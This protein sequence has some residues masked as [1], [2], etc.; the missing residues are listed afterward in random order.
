MEK[1]E[2]KVLNWPPGGEKPVS[3]HKKTWCEKRHGLTFWSLSQEGG[4][5]P[6]KFQDLL[7]TSGPKDSCTKLKKKLHQ[8]APSGGKTWIFRSP[9]FSQIF[10]TWCEFGLISGGRG[11]WP[12]FCEYYPLGGPT[13]IVKFQLKVLNWPPG[14]GKPL[15]FCIMCLD[16]S[17]IV[18]FT[19][20]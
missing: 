6:W 11:P 8:G 12:Y 1:L 14:G 9:L 7:S 18:T 4:T 16:Q 20:C 13:S 15:N 10:K 3:S 2:Q 5:L 17:S 19:W